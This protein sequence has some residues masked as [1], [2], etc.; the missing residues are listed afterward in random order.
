MIKT[1]VEETQ[2]ELDAIEKEIDDE[3]NM[4]VQIHE[5]RPDLSIDRLIARQ[6]ADFVGL[7][8]DRHKKRQL[9]RM[10]ENQMEEMKRK[11]GETTY[12]NAQPWTEGASNQ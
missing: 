5:E 7:L 10:F 12:Q 4:L 3:M 6:Q 2:E 8:W 11:K 1:I 9:L